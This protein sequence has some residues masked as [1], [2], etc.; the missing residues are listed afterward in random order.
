[1][2][3]A[4][5]GESA[6]SMAA[7]VCAIGKSMRPDLVC[8]DIEIAEKLYFEC[9]LVEDDQT[10]F[11]FF[12]NCGKCRGFV[13]DRNTSGFVRQ[14]RACGCLVA[15]DME[16]NR[17]RESGNLSNTKTARRQLNEPQE[18]ALLAK[19]LFSQHNKSSREELYYLHSNMNR[20]KRLPP[21]RRHVVVSTSTKTRFRTPKVQM[22]R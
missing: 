10:W 3:A 6:H 9:Q 17:P 11:P 16:F 15:M 18:V 1:V 12:E 13:F 22:F 2:T 14:F 5:S 20:G 21:N 8:G 7:I 4:D 19:A